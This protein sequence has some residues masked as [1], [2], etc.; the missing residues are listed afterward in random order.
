M[1]ASLIVVRVFTRLHIL[2]T[3]PPTPT[4]PPP[5]PLDLDCVAEILAESN[6][7]S[8]DCTSS[9]DLDVLDFECSV[10]GQPVTD[11]CER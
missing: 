2:A 4:T 10:N 11:G 7:V 9:R 1:L 8:V 3:V 6:Q 5:V